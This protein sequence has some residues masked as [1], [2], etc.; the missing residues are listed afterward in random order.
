MQDARLKQFSRT[1]SLGIVGGIVMMFM[2]SGVSQQGPELFLVEG[3]ILLGGWA[4]MIWGCVNYMRWKGYSG[5][6]GLF[7][8][9]LLPGLII[10]VCFPNRRTRIPQMHQSEYISKTAAVSGEYRFLLAVAPLGIIFIVL[11]GFVHRVRSNTDAAEW[12]QVAPPG[13]GFEALVPGTPRLEQQTRETP[14]GRVELH[15]FTVTPKGKKKLIAFVVRRLPS[16]KWP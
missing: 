7:G 8:Y 13:M 11:S 10:L 5:W 14:A 16:E 15:K 9:L 12:E 4:L 1:A 3:A 2:G 6:F